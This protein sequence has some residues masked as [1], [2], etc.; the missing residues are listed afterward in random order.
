MLDGAGT[1]P[2]PD[3]VG[4]PED[5]NEEYNVARMAA[6]AW[7]IGRLPPGESNLPSGPAKSSGTVTQVLGAL[8][9]L[10]G[11]EQQSRV[12]ALREAELTCAAGDRLE[13]LTGTPGPG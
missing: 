7:L 11:E 13:I 10:P 4:S 2:C 5:P 6:A 1:R 12:A 9:A 3:L 8:H